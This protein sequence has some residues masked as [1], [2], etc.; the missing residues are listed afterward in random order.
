MERAY[1]VQELDELRRAVEEKL[2]WGSYLPKAG[3][4]LGQ[5]YSPKD[6]SRQVEERVRTHMLAGHTATDLYN[7]E[8]SPSA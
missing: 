8:S 4:C 3:A 6:L 2:I 5:S 1:T 7:S